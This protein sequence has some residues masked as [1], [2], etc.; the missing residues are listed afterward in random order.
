MLTRQVAPAHTTQGSPN[1]EP[2][3]LALLVY[4]VLVLVGGAGAVA[5]ARRRLHGE[6]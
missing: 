3:A 6:S 5:L 1:A 2:P 4:L